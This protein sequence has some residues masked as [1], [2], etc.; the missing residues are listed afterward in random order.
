MLLIAF[1]LDESPEKKNEIIRFYKSVV[2]FME[3]DNKYAELKEL[4]DIDKIIKIFE[5]W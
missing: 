1:D 4:T 3:D 2:S 5:L